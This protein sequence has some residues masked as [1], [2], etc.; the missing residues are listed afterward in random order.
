MDLFLSS[1]SFS[2]LLRDWSFITSFAF[3]AALAWLN[4]DGAQSTFSGISERLP[5]KKSENY[6]K[7]KSSE[8]YKKHLE[9]KSFMASKQENC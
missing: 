1:Q 7:S 4:T 8:E 6:E 5:E 9:Q 2:Y 3:G